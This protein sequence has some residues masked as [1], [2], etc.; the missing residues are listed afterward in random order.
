[1]KLSRTRPGVVT[2]VATDAELAALAAG[3][4]LALSLLEADPRAPAEAT[5]AL[6]RVLDDYDRG[7]ARL[8]GGPSPP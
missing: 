6:A 2:V 5:A 8:S 1:M 3:A 7:A 4:R